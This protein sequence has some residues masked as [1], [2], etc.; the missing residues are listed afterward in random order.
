MKQVNHANK[1][2][3]LVTYGWKQHFNELISFALCDYEVLI[4]HAIT[5][6]CP[7]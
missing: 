5:E 4:R 6:D 7:Q 2:F 1:L 3:V